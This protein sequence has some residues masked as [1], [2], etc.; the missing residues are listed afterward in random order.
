MDQLLALLGE[1]SYP[2][3]LKPLAA[4]CWRGAKN[5]EI[6]GGRKAIVT[7]SPEEL[8]TEY[9]LIARADRRALVQEM[10]PGGDEHLVIAACYFDRNSNC[11]AVFNAQKL[12]QEPEGF[13]TG[14]IVQAVRRPELRHPTIRL[15]EAMRF[16]GI[17][18]VEYKWDVAADAYK[19]IEINPRP[20]DQHRLGKSCGV[21]LILLAYCDHV[22]LALPVMS[23]DA[24]L[25]TK[26]VGE[27][28]FL[29]LALKYIWRR[30]PRL[31]RLFRLA[32]GKRA[33]AIWSSKDP[34]PFFAY[35]LL[36]AMPQVGFAAGRMIWS[37][38][39]RLTRR[40]D[41][42]SEMRYGQ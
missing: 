13:G 4:H 27:D 37:V 41:V 29:M 17:A 23:S 1:V 14:C 36:A 33:Y 8:V 35:L 40:G 26:W 6:V 12:L 10:V 22:G 3:V 38:L 34:L 19:L 15:L 9:S 21:D 32:R 5:W 11:L 18:E 7:S 16:T 28:S 2:C 31:R 39:A 25:Y 24:G 30:D 20:W 42:R